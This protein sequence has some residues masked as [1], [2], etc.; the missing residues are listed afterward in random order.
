MTWRNSGFEY[1][2]RDAVTSKLDVLCET[3]PYLEELPPDEGYQDCPC[4][5]DPTDFNCANKVTVDEI[6]DKVL[7]LDTAISEALIIA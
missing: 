7:E 6:M 5:M 3:C 1:I 2:N 4:G